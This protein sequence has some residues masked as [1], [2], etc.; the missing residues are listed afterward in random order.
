MLLLF[1]LFVAAAAASVQTNN[2]SVSLHSYTQCMYVQQIPT[3]SAVDSEMCAKEF[4]VSCALSRSIKRSY[5]CVC[6]LVCCI[7][8]S[9]QKQYKHTHIC[10]SF[11]VVF[12]ADTSVCELFFVH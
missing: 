1:F 8:A 3:K 5:A 7:Y 4:A 10:F 2:A 11:V 6:V 9:L 12:F